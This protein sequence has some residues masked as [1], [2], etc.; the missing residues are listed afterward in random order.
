VNIQIYQQQKFVNDH[1]VDMMKGLKQIH[2]NILAFQ[3]EFRKLGDKLRQAQTN[4]D[5]ADRSLSV[6]SK[7]IRMLETTT[8]LESSETKV[9]LI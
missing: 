2:I 9:E 7:E 8:E 1:A 6:V 3:D 5:S 4:Y